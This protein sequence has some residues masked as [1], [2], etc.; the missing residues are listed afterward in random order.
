MTAMAGPLYKYA[1]QLTYHKVW[2]LERCK[3][4]R[5]QCV[6]STLFFIGI[7]IMVNWRPDNMD[8]TTIV[9][10]GLVTAVTVYGSALT[11]WKSMLICI[12][13]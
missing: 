9:T 1:W 5:D 4:L 11:V 3:Q 7:S 12:P 10:G 13:S 8:R 2:Q 6:N